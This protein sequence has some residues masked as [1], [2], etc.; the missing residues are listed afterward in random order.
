MLIQETKFVPKLN[1]F[2]ESFM[3]GHDMLSNAFSKSTRRIRPSIF[4]SLHPIVISYISLVQA[5]LQK[6]FLLGTD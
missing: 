5:S 2:S 1:C 3:K 4:C 6:T